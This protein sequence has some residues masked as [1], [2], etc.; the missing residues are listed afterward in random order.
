MK[1]VTVVGAALMAVFLA[2]CGVVTRKNAA[3]NTVIQKSANMRLCAL[4]DSIHSIT[5]DYEAEIGAVL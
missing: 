3:E 1:T 5:E 4:K 2:A